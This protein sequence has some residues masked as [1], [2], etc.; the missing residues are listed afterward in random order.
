ME[1]SFVGLFI[2]RNRNS[3]RPG[4]KCPKS[5]FNSQLLGWGQSGKT[6][7]IETLLSAM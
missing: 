4:I 2:K 3:F 5:G 1:K 7:L 6:I